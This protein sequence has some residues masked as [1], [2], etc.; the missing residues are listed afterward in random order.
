MIIPRS[1]LL[2]NDND[3]PRTESPRASFPWIAALE[4]THSGSGNSLGE[5]SQAAAACG[6]YPANGRRTLTKKEDSCARQARWS[7]AKR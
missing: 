5:P 4:T 1:A 3:I 6:A 7:T 2:T